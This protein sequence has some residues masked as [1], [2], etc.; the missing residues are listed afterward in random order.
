MIHLGVRIGRSFV[1]ACCALGMISTV[2]RAQSKAEPRLPMR[3]PV[4]V[5]AYYPVKGDSIDIGVTGDWARA[6]PELVA[7]M[8]REG[9]GLKRLKGR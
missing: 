2:V 3:V 8:V 1:I 4:L 5:I 7:R 9:R 6:H